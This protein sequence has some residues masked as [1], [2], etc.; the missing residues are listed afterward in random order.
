MIPTVRVA[1][2]GIESRQNSTISPPKHN[3]SS[4][5]ILHSNA[6]TGKQIQVGPCAG[7]PCISH[8]PCVHLQDG[9]SMHPSIRHNP[10]FILCY[11]SRQPY[12]HS[13]G[14]VNV[15][16]THSSYSR[17]IWIDCT[18]LRFFSRCSARI[19][20]SRNQYFNV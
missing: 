3:F 7:K 18:C 16:F 12:I 5:D 15:T 14:S 10:Y 20:I 6:I 17:T 2:I 19:G 8:E 9:P 11:S 13:T 1:L 4:S